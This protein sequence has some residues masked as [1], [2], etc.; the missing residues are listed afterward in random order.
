[1]RKTFHF[2]GFQKLTDCYKLSG[3]YVKK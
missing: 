1:M 2:T 3:D